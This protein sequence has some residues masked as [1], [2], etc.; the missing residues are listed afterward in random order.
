MKRFNNLFNKII[1]KEN[2]R[3]AHIN[4]RKGK[5]R[6]KEVIYVDNNLEKCIVE[7]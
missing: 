7:G 1:D 3:L 5:S 6:Y 2:L 4:A